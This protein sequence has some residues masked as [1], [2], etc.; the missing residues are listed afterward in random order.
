MVIVEGWVRLESSDEIERLRGATIEVIRA[1]RAEEPGCLDYACAIDLSDS[2]LLRI[3]ER[4]KDEASL[5]A[6]FTAPHVAA[7]SQVLAG[8]RIVGA[9]VKAYSGEVIRPVME[10]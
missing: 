9:S 6:H 5:S 8:A 2:T 3:V 10:R 7:F 4:W 1:S